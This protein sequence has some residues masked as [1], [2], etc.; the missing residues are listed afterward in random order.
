MKIENTKITL[1]TNQD[2][3]NPD[4]TRFI[5]PMAQFY[6][7]DCLRC[8]NEPGNEPILQHVGSSQDWDQLV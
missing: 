1:E 6:V 4:G 3:L 7:P 8:D 2:L 5:G